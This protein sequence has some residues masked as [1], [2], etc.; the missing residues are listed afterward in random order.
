MSSSPSFETLT[1]PAR[2]GTAGYIPA[3][4]SIPRFDKFLYG[5]FYIKVGEA[6]ARSLQTIFDSGGM[7]WPN[8][9]FGP[10]VR[11]SDSLSTHFPGF[12]I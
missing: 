7:S 9:Q 2:P 8:F 4:D 1:I 5:L 12:E 11:D 6:P 10:S 3:Y